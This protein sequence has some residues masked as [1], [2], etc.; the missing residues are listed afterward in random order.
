MVMPAIQLFEN[1][2]PLSY[3]F[4]DL[5]KFHG[6]N[7]PGG[8]AQAIKVMEKALPILA[9]D[10]Y[11]E[12]REIKIDT[13]FTGPGV[14]DSFEMMCRAVSE[15]RYHIDPALGEPWAEE[16]HRGIFFFRLTYRGRVAEVVIRPG[17]LRDEFFDLVGKSDKSNDEVMRIAELKTEMANRLMQVD[18][19]YVY[20]TVEEDAAERG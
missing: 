12:R 14:R 19:R 15:D 3:S 17:H 1:G 20:A 4:A 16:G 11:V 7:A 10:G 6:F 18:G 8:I 2:R 13:S 9:P 5:E